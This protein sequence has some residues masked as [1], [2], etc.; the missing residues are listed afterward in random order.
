ST[1][2]PVSCNFLTDPGCDPVQI[3]DVPFTITDQGSKTGQLYGVYLQDEWKLTPKLTFNYGARFDVVRAYTKESQF[4]PRANLVWTA[5][6]LTTVHIG[7]ARNFTPPP[8]ELIAPATVALYNGTTKQSEIQTGDPVKAER[9]HYF[10]AGVEQRFPGGF[11][12]GLDAY[13]KIKRN[14]LDEGQFGAAVVLSPFNYAK[15]YAWGV[16]LSSN[17]THGPIDL[18]ANVARGQEKAKDIVS[19]QYFFAPDELAYIRDNYIYTDH[20]QKWTAS[21]GGS[22]TIHDSLGTLV[23]TADFIFASGLR[24]DDPGG[25]IPNGGELPSYFVLNAGVAQTFTGPGVLNGVTIRADVLNL[26]D[27]VYQIR[28]GSGVGVG[29]PQWGQRRGFFAGITKKF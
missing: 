14:L 11:K 20:S 10:D 27:E 7:Y 6:P 22:Y 29:A 28:S 19:A 3:S 8:Q 9:E 17:Y 25:I 18:Y 13:Y 1:V 4:S 2:L 21:G 26:F 24:T 23:P 12:L 5:T 16:E 15:G